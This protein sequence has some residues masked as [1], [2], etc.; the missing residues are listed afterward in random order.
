MATDR[1]W[2]VWYELMTGNPAAVAPFYKAVMGWDIPAEGM[3]M[4]NGADYRFIARADGGHEGAVLTYDA[5]NAGSPSMWAVYFST[6]DCD[7]AVDQALAMGATVHMPPTSLPGAGRIAM[8][9]DPQ[10]A[11]FYLIDPQP[12]EGE[13][14]P[15]IGVFDQTRPGH[16]CWHELNTDDAPG[17][18]VFYT[19]LL[20]WQVNGEMPMPDGHSYRF[21]EAGGT[22]IGAIGSMKPDGMP[23]LW[24]PYF[25]VASIAAAQ[26]A[27]VAN[28]GTVVMGPHDVPGED[29]IIVATD[30]AGAAVGFVGHTGS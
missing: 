29:T 27:V 16:C 1:G 8:L 7:A 26:S 12:P 21:L 19:S 28:G 15:A 22:G 20:G 17:Q 6:P 25:R 30:P 10:G 2:P 5:A 13:A 14:P 11:M 3:V 4:A 23:S 9:A 24:L 18:E